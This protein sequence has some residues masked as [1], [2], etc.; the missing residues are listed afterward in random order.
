MEPDVDTAIMLELEEKITQRIRT[1]IMKGL[2]GS[3]TY[4]P[5]NGG[6][7]AVNIRAHVVELIGYQLIN[8]PT[9]LTD[10][11]KKIGMKMSNV[12]Y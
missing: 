7:A 2:H 8:N 9:F 1:E 3:D 5:P 6:L 4:Q 10:L 11:T 12:P